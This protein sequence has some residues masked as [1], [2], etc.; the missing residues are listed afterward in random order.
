MS[1]CETLVLSLPRSPAGTWLEPGWLETCCWENNKRIYLKDF[2][3]ICEIQVL[4]NVSFKVPFVTQHKDSAVAEWKQLSLSWFFPATCERNSCMFFQKGAQFVVAN[5]S[6]HRKGVHTGTN[7][8]RHSFHCSLVVCFRLCFTSA[9]FPEHGHV[10]DSRA[11][12]GGFVQ[13]RIF[14]IHAAHCRGLDV[15]HSGNH[16]YGSLDDK[17]NQRSRKCTREAPICLGCHTY[18]VQQ[19][20]E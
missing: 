11:T 19:Q 8:Q 15:V 1:V 6:W 7:S 3:W 10:A 17:Q 2:Q 9:F 5:T 18:I 20:G 13:T 16:T 4:L 14:S 12:F